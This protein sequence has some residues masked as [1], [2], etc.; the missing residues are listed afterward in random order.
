LLRPVK[1]AARLAAKPLMK[2]GHSRKIDGAKG[3]AARK[4][5]DPRNQAGLPSEA[6]MT[7]AVINSSKLIRRVAFALVVLPLFGA[8]ALAAHA[9]PHQGQMSRGRKHQSRLQIDRLEEMWRNATLK[10]DTAALGSLLA[11]DY[12]A[13]TPGG[14]LLSKEQTLAS[15]RSG[16]T[17]FTAIEVSDRKVRFYG[18]TALLTSRAEIS[19]SIA[20][21]NIS[22]S[23]R[24]T[25]VYARDK[26]GAWKI[27]SFE[28]SRIREAGG[29]R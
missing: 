17:H 19:G 1:V 27:V 21:Q 7:G 10:A 5:I 9:A 25:H 11:D 18:T 29:R 6:M 23:F 16:T 13:I 14:T 2:C 15:L 8:L 28:A 26:Q 12:M 24:Y 3:R 22:G 4:A 20:G